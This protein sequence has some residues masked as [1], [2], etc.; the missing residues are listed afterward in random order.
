MTNLTR[1]QFSLRTAQ[2]STRAIFSVGFSFV[3]FVEFGAFFKPF[4]YICIY[5]KDNLVIVTIIKPPVNYFKH[6]SKQKQPRGKQHTYV[7]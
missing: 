6:K 4:K 5:N 7:T 3:S 1:L 2:S